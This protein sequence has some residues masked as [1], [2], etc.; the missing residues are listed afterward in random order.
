MK[1]ISIWKIYLLI[2]TT[3]TRHVKYILRGM[4]IY[5]NM[6]YIYIYIYIYIHFEGCHI[7]NELPTVKI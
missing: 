4:Q 6:K 7:N 2:T 3:N 1:N 5:G